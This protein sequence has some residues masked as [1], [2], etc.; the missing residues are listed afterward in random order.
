MSTW[1]I[2]PDKYLHPDEVKKLRASIHA[3]AL[4]AKS[5]GRQVGYKAMVIIEL[6]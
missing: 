2:T 5:K 4:L 1:I 3:T 6:A